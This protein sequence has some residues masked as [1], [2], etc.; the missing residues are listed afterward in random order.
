[1]P[2]VA[3]GRALRDDELLARRLGVDAWA[4]GADRAADVLDGWRTEPPRVLAEGADVP[5]ECFV[6][7]THRALLLAAAIRPEDAEAGRDL[8]DEVNRLLD[9][10]QGALLLESPA[11]FADQVAVLRE[12]RNAPGATGGVLDR[13]ITR[14]VDATDGALPGTHG[15]LRSVAPGAT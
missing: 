12:N 7:D 2:V 3:G 10:I 8:V 1:V 4:P 6:I 14:L 11:L 13:V 5:P 15:L 9:V